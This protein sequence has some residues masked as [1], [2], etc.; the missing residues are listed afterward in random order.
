MKVS[1][2]LIAALA[3]GII[4]GVGSTAIQMSM[5]DPQFDTTS[6]TAKTPDNA[7]LIRGLTPGHAPRVKVMNGV[8]HAFEMMEVGTTGRHDFVLENVGT[9]PLKVEKGSTSCQ[10]TISEVADGAVDPGE[11]V[12]VTV[13]WKA[14]EE[15]DFRQVADL[16]TNDPLSPVL[17]LVVEGYVTQSTRVIPEDVALGRISSSVPTTAQFSVFS[18]REDFQIEDYEFLDSSTADYFELDI[19]RFSPEEA[20]MPTDLVK[21]AL[22]VHVRI[23]P[24]LPLGPIN[25]TIRLTTNLEDVTEL[26]V[27]V[28]GLVISDVSILGGRSFNDYNNELNLGLIRS[29]TGGSAQLHVLVKGPERHEVQ[30]QVTEIDPAGVLE[31]ELGEAKDNGAVLVYPL[32]IRVP[33]GAAPIS[34]L[35]SEA[36]RVT[37]ETTHQSARKI[38]LRVKFSVGSSS[39]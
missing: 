12:I 8:E 31:A 16:R 33:P 21:A 36:G 9:L 37:I 4:A 18:L 11:Q 3:I 19:Q 39:G 35:G 23:K 15:G 10:C 32:T 25:Q 22:M 14:E 24:G 29:S 1:I 27:P 28:S 17:H 6:S 30:L 2:V 26:E 5:A 20:K 34:R 13:E 7:A 38:D